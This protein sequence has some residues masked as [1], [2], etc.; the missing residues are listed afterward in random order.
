MSVPFLSRSMRHGDFMS[1]ALPLAR[2][3]LAVTTVLAAPA[4]LLAAA[5]ADDKSVADILMAL[6]HQSWVAWKAQ[7]AKFFEGFLSEDHVE[8][9]PQGPADKAGVV[10]GVAQAGCKVE[11]N[12]ITRFH[13]TRLSQDSALLVYRAEQETTCGGAAVPSPTWATSVY[14][15]RG[16]QWKNVLYQQLPATVP[17]AIPGP[18]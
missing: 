4:A 8:L 13:F 3:V 2:I 1:P 7:D 11:S 12:S 16:G 10:R 18:P 17:G 6:E 9:W 15:L 5:P 14:A